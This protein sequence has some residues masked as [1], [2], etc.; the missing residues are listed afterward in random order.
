MIRA[1]DAPVAGDGRN[2]GET[3]AT[4]IAQALRRYV[5]LVDPAAICHLDPDRAVAVDAPLQ[6]NPPPG[7]P[8]RERAG[9]A[10]GITHELAHHEQRILDLTGRRTTTDQIVAYKMTS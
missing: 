10:D 6:P 7:A 1:D 8:D 5:R 2:D 9:V 4:G 3:A